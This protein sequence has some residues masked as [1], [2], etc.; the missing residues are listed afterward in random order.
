MH[1]QTL[2]MKRFWTR[3][4]RDERGAIASASI[5][6]VYSILALGAITGLICLRNQ[7]VQELGDLA[8]AFDNLDQSYQVDW[9][10]DG[11]VDATY[12]DPPPTLTDPTGIAPAG[13]MLDDPAER[14]AVEPSSTRP[15][16]DSKTL[17][18]NR[19][20]NFKVVGSTLRVP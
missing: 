17:R 19:L 14:K 1:R 5:I 3:F 2:L 4:W 10:A 13:I 6:L 9:D 8:V 20:T 18:Q 16:R 7:I 11:I 15:A 12:V